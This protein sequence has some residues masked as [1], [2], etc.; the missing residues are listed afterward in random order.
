MNN[1]GFTLIEL[2]AIIALIS[3]ITLITIP[4]IQYAHKKIQE[5]NY[6]AKKEVIKAAAEDYGE[7]YKEIILYGT[8]N[9]TDCSSYNAKCVKVTVQTLLNSG[10]LVKDSD[11][12]QNEVDIR[13]PRD[14][15]SILNKDI[16]IYIKN[17]RAYADLKF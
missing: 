17:N 3:I 4:M 1:K 2:L 6:N 8:G 7:D 11:L 5:S 15:S 14:D 10:Y 16:Y 13:D 9:T 12:P